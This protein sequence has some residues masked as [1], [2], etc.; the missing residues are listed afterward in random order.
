[1]E[2]V[3]SVGQSMEYL[4][5]DIPVRISQ[6][7]CHQIA[8]RK[9]GWWAVLTVS[10]QI[11]YNLLRRRY[12]PKFTCPR[13]SQ[14]S[15]TCGADC[16]PINMNVTAGRCQRKHSRIR[17]TTHKSPPRGLLF[18]FRACHDQITNVM[19]MGI[20]SNQGFGGWGLQREAI[21]V[22]LSISA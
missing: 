9:T 3:D 21:A 1:M 8:G 4:D 2:K 12:P 10:R 22:T 15:Y 17:K 19:A 7:R 20:C 13:L 14:I 18:R 6:S 11:S 16:Q 5:L